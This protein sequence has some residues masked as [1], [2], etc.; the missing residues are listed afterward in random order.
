[1]YVSPLPH[2]AYTHRPS[3]A[4]M[5]INLLLELLG[6]EEQAENIQALICTGIAKLML[7]G[8]VSDESVLQALVLVYMSPETA[9]NQELRQCLSYF[10][11][12]YCYS[13]PANQQRMQQVR[14]KVAK[15]EDVEVLTGDHRASYLS[16]ANYAKR[17]GTWT[18]T[19][20]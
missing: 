8:M 14:A 20:I 11:P 15:G 9:R 4:H 6:K 3:Q 1:M 2:Y 17:T 13:V 10:F 12:V 5:I 16:S 7:A 18:A 19:K